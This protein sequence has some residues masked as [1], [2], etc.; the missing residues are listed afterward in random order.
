M[1]EYGVNIELICFSIIEAK[2]IFEA[3]SNIAQYFKGNILENNNTKELIVIN[4]KDISQI[5][6]HYG[7]I[8]KS[9]IGRY[10]EMNNQIVLLEKEIMGLNNKMVLVVE[11]HK[12]EL[13]D[14]E[15]EV[16]IEKHKNEL[17]DKD[18]EILHYK[19]KLL[20]K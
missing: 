14:K 16:L 18:I 17:K 1:K 8:Q 10:E 20:E 4:K 19:I 12:N 13:Q 5:K 15:R 3:E 2:Y 7:M 11:K 6:Q 9:Y